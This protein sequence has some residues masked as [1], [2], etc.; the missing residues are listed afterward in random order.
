LIR[1]QTFLSAGVLKR[2]K[3]HAPAALNGIVGAEA[4]TMQQKKADG[5]NKGR[6][7]WMP[8]V[9]ADPRGFTKW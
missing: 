3:R 1:V 4:L 8:L 6:I 5:T 9:L 2:R 7:Y